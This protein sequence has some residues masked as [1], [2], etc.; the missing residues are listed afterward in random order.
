MDPFKLMHRAATAY[1]DDIHKPA[2]G[3][4]CRSVTGGRYTLRKV[5]VSVN[6]KMRKGET[7]SPGFE[8]K[9][10]HYAGVK[11]SEHQL[12]GVRSQPFSTQRNRFIGIDNMTLQGRRSVVCG[13]G[14]AERPAGHAPLPRGDKV[15][16]RSL[17]L[18]NYSSAA[19]G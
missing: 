4:L 2:G 19:R 1:V 8:N 11:R 9:G 15:I 18:H 17:D 14:L 16:M 12:L 10:G 5:P 3:I 6:F 13:K 7:F